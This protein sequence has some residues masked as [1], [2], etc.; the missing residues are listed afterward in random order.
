MAPEIP[1][2][3]KSRTETIFI[4]PTGEYLDY[5]ASGAGP[6]REEERVVIEEK[7]C[8]QC[9][10]TMRLDSSSMTLVCDE[11]GLSE[12]AIVEERTDL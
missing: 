12:E 10:E 4:D 11:C 5:S 2:G 7:P 1:N 6:Q 8:G 3:W 9:G